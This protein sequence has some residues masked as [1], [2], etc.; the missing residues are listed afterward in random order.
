MN[1][2]AVPARVLAIDDDPGVL[3]AV[4][5]ILAG[6]YELAS[7]SSPIEALELARGFRPDLA[8]LDIRMPAMDGFELMQRLRVEHPNVD[9][10][11]VTGS[12]TDPDAHLIR[13]IE[14]GAFYFIQKP[15]DRQV[16]QTL[17]QRCLELRHL[18]LQADRE[19]QQL[20]VLQNQ[21]LPQVP[22]AHGE[23][24][25][26]F[27]Y[28]PFY[29]AT[30]DYHDFFPQPDGSLVVFVGDSC[31]HGP[32]ACMLMATMRT[33]LYTHPDILSD[34]GNALS[35]LSAM[36]HAL[37]PSDLFMTALLLRLESGGRIDW[38]AAGQYPPLRITGE[39]VAPLTE[40][41][42]GLP[43]GIFPNER[44]ETGSCRMIPGERL[45]AFTDGIFEASNRQG[46]QFGTAGIKSSLVKLAHAAATSEALLDA[47]IEDVKEHMEGQTFEDDFTLIAVERK[48]DGAVPLPEAALK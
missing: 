45:I 34:P 46:K 15:F 42:Q 20:R 47:L 19:L 48:I 14:Q 40:A 38:A 1:L 32:S 31:G 30:G 11:F 37:I 23:Y 6:Q 18:R 8:L 16:L 2:R 44:Y 36:F 25:I 7:T 29:F 35:R 24:Q 33:L 17:I 3:H 9:I 10:I 21:L 28:R 26:A 39:Q 4:K 13:A 22:P 27:R 43:L 12:M 5:R 41:K